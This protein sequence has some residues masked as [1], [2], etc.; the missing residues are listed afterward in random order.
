MAEFDPSQMTQEVLHRLREAAEQSW[1]DDTRHKNFEGYAQPSSGQCY[2]TSKWMADKFGGHVGVKGGHY[3][4]VSP[5]KDYVVDLTGDQFAYSPAD[6]KYHGL[7][8]DE[9]DSGWEPTEDQ[10]RH[11]P[12]PILFKRTTHPLYDGF[13]VKD[14]PEAT[15]EGDE[16]ES[17]KRSNLFSQRANEAYNA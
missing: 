6:L 15:Q 9:D 14:S 7:K 12:G 11:R 1:G 8:M 4:W 2:V 3:F 10:K 16:Q 13:R 5:D 17:I